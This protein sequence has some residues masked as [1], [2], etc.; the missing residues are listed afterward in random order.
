ML[1]HSLNLPLNEDE[2]ALADALDRFIAGSLAPT[3]G[4]YVANHAFPEP[5]LRE[6]LS[7]GF[8]GAAFPDALGGAGLGLRG[9]GLVVERLAQCDPGF[10][11][12]VLC[13]SASM[14]VLSRFATPEQ[15]AR[16]L[17]PLIK[18]EMLSSFGVSETQ[19][20]SDPASTRTSAAW[21]GTDWV[22]NGSKVFST[23]A[24]TALH[25]L[26][27]VLAQT[28]PAAGTRGL[29]TF[30]VPAG[31]QGFTIA[32]PRK[33]IG[34]RVA[35]TVELYFDNVRLPSDHQ[36]GR[37]GDGLKQVLVALA[38]GR[39]LV[40]ACALGLTGKALAAAS[41]YARDRYLQGEPIISNQ[42]V[43]FRLVDLGARYLAAALLTRHAADL[44]DTGHAARAETS[45]AKLLASE[46]AVDAALTAV[47]LHGAYG[48][49]YDQ[50]VSGL[51]GEAKVLE[52]VEGVSEVQRLLMAREWFAE[53]PA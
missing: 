33:K 8:M 12:I 48:I 51:I 31:T 28:D 7:L 13:N 37:P 11:A 29:S 20:G 44:V 38:A 17:V 9:G 42:A 2:R 40:A 6:F 47:H 16:W 1:P 41:A 21:T 10:A 23:N 49:F 34:W 5:I 32:P 30:I 22:L 18:G 36:I 26:S 46:L 50:D 45:A 25:G 52:I 19:G 39:I 43:S 15:Q 35:P 4:T 24:G 3:I 53:V 14:S 27:L